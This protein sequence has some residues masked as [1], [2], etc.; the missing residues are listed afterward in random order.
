ME[1]SKIDYLA[2]WDLISFVN[3]GDSSK[4]IQSEA[5]TVSEKAHRYFIDFK[6]VVDIDMYV[7]Y[8]RH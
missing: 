7:C 3:F 6:L 4:G 8:H 1:H 5:R 2:V